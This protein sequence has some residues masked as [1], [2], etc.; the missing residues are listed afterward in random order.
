M[1]SQTSG[2]F[3]PNECARAWWR[4]VLHAVRG[5][6][7]SIGHK[8]LAFHL[9]IAPSLLSEAL[10]ERERK[11]FQL[12]WLPVVLMLSDELHRVSILSALAEPAGYDLAKRRRLTPQ[13]RLDKL[14]SV[15]LNRLGSL[16]QQLLEEVGE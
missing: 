8:E 9:D 11:H 13:E 5:A 3:G 14:E 16:G 1:N 7:D 4:K 6:V 15:V 12:R 10:H 2:E